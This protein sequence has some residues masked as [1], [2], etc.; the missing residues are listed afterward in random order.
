MTWTTPVSFSGE[1]ADYIE[2]TN[3]SDTMFGFPANDEFT[4]KTSGYQRITV[5]SDGK[6]GII[7]TSPN[8]TL[9]VYGSVNFTAAL[10]VGGQHGTT[11]QVLTSAGG[12]APT[13][14][15]LTDDIDDYIRHVNNTTTRFGFPSDNT[16][17]I[18]TD[19]SERL[20]IDSSG[21][22]GIGT[23]SPSYPLHVIGHA[24][25][26]GGL[27]ANGSSG[28]SGQVLTSS[29]GGAMSWTTI[30]SGAWTTSGSDVYRSSGQVG[31][32]TTSPGA[33]LEIECADSTS[34]S[35]GLFVKQSSSSYPA[36]LTIE[37]SSYNQD[38]YM[39][40][41]YSDMG[42]VGWSYVWI[43]PIVVK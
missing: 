40:F 7:Q 12:N 30:S 23:T 1:I 14:T 26:T 33:P 39:T 22:V 17:T 9:D 13:W 2:H 6:V 8:Y 36:R 35:N 27:R 28:S 24:N 43:V 3:D 16:F 10:S 4:I 31:I 38:P 18:D 42:T 19:G 15:T 41:Q 29:G 34:G 11:G 25:I 37:T 20:R 21:Y 32:G 5:K